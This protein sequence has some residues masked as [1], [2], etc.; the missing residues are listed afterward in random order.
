MWYLLGVGF[1]Q[2][3]PLHWQAD[4]LPLDHQG[5]LLDYYYYFFFL[6]RIP[7][8]VIYWIKGL[9]TPQVT[10]FLGNTFLQKY[11]IMAVYKYITFC[12]IS[13]T[14]GIS[15]LKELIS[16]IQNVVS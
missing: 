9:K 11:I 13:E 2:L 7:V 1:E 15:N 14:L 12:E 6:R 8:S 4:S 5:S 10:Y 3:C 16:K